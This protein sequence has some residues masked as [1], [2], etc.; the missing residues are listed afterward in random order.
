MRS[1]RRGRVQDLL[2]GRA[3][4]RAEKADLNH[5]RGPLAWRGPVYFEMFVRRALARA[6]ACVHVREEEGLYVHYAP[7]LRLGYIGAP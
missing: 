1:P 5:V 7:T 2:R 3:R 6:R 4:A